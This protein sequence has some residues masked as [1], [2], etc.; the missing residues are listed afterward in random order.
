MEGYDKFQLQAGGTDHFSK[1]K[2]RE[3]A[4]SD[5]R[6]GSFGASNSEPGRSGESFCADI[7]RVFTA[8]GSGRGRRL[9]HVVLPTVSLGSG[10]PKS[11]SFTTF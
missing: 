3:A 4:T 9:L 10:S 8:A 1:G 6:L 7:Q 5:L 2:P 11:L